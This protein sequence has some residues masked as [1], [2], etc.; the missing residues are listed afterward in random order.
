MEAAEFDPDAWD[1]AVE[2]TSG[3]DRWC[4]GSAW[5][6]G[7][8]SWWP[9]EQRLVLRGGHG[10]ASFIRFAGEDG[11]VRFIGPD[12]VWGFA[13]AVVG[14]VPAVADELAAWLQRDDSWDLTVLPGVAE[15]SGLW[16]ALAGALSPI[17]RLFSGEVCVRRV[18]DLDG[19]A[20]AWLARRSRKFRVSLRHAVSACERA[21][22]HVETADQIDV[23][24]FLERI[25]A[26]EQQSFKGDNGVR[27]PHMTELY[28]SLLCDLVP[29]GAARVSF[30]VRDG[31][32][33]GYI[34]GGARGPTYRGL[35]FSYVEEVRDLG[36]G[37]VLQWHE[38][39]R[40][41]ALGLT[42]Y[43]LGMDI[44]YKRRWA[45]R[46][47]ETGSIVVVRPRVP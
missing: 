8:A 39:R 35:Q 23:E 11:R 1:A 13:S 14:D 42:R 46:N 41:A 24:A 20:E 18:I 3:I 38:I 9:A 31:R 7:L 45:D 19:G 36:V 21:G 2:R 5:V 47:D 33:I 32:D 27:S 34:F 30:A 22:V 25:L 29:K 17:G 6:R 44:E 16:D 10:W 26:I 43:D 40:A 37:N 15:G 28:R 4:S 12:P